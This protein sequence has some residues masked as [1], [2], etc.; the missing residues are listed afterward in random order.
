[1]QPPVFRMDNDIR[2]FPQATRDLVVYEAWRLGVFRT[3]DIVKALQ[4]KYERWTDSAAV[5][6]HLTALRAAGVL[7]RPSRGVYVH[8]EHKEP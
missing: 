7:S 4:D 6:H 2:Y 5:L 1:M 3:P 8:R